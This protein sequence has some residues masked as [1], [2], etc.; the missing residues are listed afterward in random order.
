MLSGIVS[1]MPPCAIEHQDGVGAGVNVSA[2][3][4]QMQ[5]HGLGIDERQHQ[6]GAGCPLGANR[7]EQVGPAI[8]AV[9]RRSGPGATTRPDPGQGALLT[10]SGLVLKPDL[11]WFASSVLG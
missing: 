10:D 11:D 2:A 7:A 1:A 8:A 3:L 5:V 6:P 4:L 9:A